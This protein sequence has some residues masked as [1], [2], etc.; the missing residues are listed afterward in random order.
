M[1][2]ILLLFG[3]SLMFFVALSPA[4]ETVFAASEILSSGTCEDV[5][6]PE[7]CA[8]VNTL[9][10][11]LNFMAIV[12]MPIITIIIIVGGIQYSVSGGEPDNVK[13]A[14]ARIF[15]AIIA[16]VFFIGLWTFLKWLIPGGWAE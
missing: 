1:V 14:R 16:L 5:T 3:L 4:V 6:K 9:N 7:S 2:S 11:V 15:K 10:T 12:I 8:A 13:K